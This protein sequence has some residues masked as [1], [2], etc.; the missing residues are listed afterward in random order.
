MILK[1]KWAILFFSKYTR[2]ALANARPKETP[3]N[4]FS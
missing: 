2:K 4:I 3:K 1:V